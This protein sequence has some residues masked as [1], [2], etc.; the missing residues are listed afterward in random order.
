MLWYE[1]EAAARASEAGEHSE[2]PDILYLQP[3]SGGGSKSK[4]VFFLLGWLLLTGVFTAI[5]FKNLLGGHT[6][7]D[8]DQHHGEC[9]SSAFAGACALTV[10]RQ[11]LSSTF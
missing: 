4:A 10:A 7:N 6:Y 8:N 1:I 3:D 9:G 2:L 11:A 5:F